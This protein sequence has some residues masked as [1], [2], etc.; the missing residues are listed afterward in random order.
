MTSDKKVADGQEDQSSLLGSVRLNAGRAFFRGWVMDEKQRAQQ[1]KFGAMRSTGE[2]PTKAEKQFRIELAA[3]ML[4]KGYSKASIK[5]TFRERWKLSAR[6]IERYLQRARDMM[7]SES[8]LSIDE[9]TAESVLFWKSRM[10]DPKLPP[11][12]QSKARENLDK[13]FGL[14]KPQKLAITNSA[15]DDIDEDEATIRAKRLEDAF[16]R[17]R[18]R[19]DITKNATEDNGPSDN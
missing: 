19:K 7:L 1:A 18:A 17:I 16:K 2:R 3:E 9:L 5:K 15:G 8:N 12:E 13:I 11:R 10:R 4:A 6:T 14:Y